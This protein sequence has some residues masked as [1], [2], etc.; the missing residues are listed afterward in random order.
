MPHSSEGSRAT[1]YGLSSAKD[2]KLYALKLLRRRYRGAH[3][4]ASNERLRPLHDLPGLAA[5]TRRVVPE[6]EPAALRCPDLAYSILIP[7]LAGSTWF[8]LLN[9]AKAGTWK[10]N[11]GVAIE[12]C[13]RFLSMMAGLEARGAAHTDISPGN[14]MID[15]RTQEVA[16]LDLEDMYLPGARRPIDPSPGAAGYR[17][18]SMTNG[19]NLWHAAGDRY[20]AAVLAAE[21]LI[22][23]E[24]HLSRL[25]TEQGF[26]TDH[27]GTE[28]GRHRYALAEPWLH[29]VAPGFLETFRQ[30][31][32]E[33]KLEGCPTLVQLRAALELAKPEIPGFVGWTK[34]DDPH[35]VPKKGTAAPP[36]Q[37]AIQPGLG[38]PAVVGFLIGLAVGVAIGLYTGQ[39]VWSWTLSTSTLG[40]LGGL[41]AAVRRRKKASQTPPPAS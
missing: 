13:H 2:G 22:L 31:W 17:H 21:I 36:P 16:L 1:V 3:L 23:A 18:V 33:S 39:S 34:W 19:A 40:W 4:V 8:D 12:L 25:A 9:E 35:H 37:R 6:A 38:E 28:V 5:A 30:S 27:Q 24:P 41:I 29:L 20:A 14:V 15:F 26:F 32:H 7:W 11:R 10:L